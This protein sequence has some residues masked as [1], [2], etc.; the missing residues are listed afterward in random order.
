MRNAGVRSGPRCTNAERR[1]RGGAE[2]LDGEQARHP[3]VGGRAIGDVARRAQ[4]HATDALEIS[5]AQHR[6]N[7]PELAQRQRRHA[8]ILGDHERD[9]RLVEAPVGVRDQLDDDVV[10]PRISRAR[11]VAGE[12]RQFL[13]VS[14]RER[15]PNLGNLLQHDEE[16]VE[17]PGAGRPDIGAGGRGFGERVARRDER[18]LGRVEPR[19]QRT[20]IAALD[21][22]GASR[23][24]DRVPPR[25]LPR[26]RAETRGAE[27]LSLHRTPIGRVR[28]RDGQV[29]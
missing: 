5:H 14:R 6:R 21:P 23:R 13:I 9:A 7:R 16:V 17:E 8:L 3:L 24:R 27:Q 12:L 11:P 18:A 26:V 4:R 10:D 20:A 28:A 25:Q 29:A 15:R 2:H 22:A 1:V 19:E